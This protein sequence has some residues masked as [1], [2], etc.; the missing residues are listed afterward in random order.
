MWSTGSPGRASAAC[1]DNIGQQAGVAR[2]GR[3]GELTSDRMRP[4][5]GNRY[6][7]RAALVDDP[8][9][10]C[11]D[12]QLQVEAE[13]K[14]GDGCGG[15]YAFGDDLTLRQDI[16]GR[17]PLPQRD[18]EGRVARLRAH[19]AQGDVAA[20]GQA[21]KIDRIAALGA[22]QPRHLV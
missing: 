4:E 22:G 3:A 2:S 11:R 15:L 8:I 17:T 9:D 13:S 10:G 1:S 14:L 21:Q 6:L 20:P 12:R 5:L 16:G 7:D 19:G 18:A